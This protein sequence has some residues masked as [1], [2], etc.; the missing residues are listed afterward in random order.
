MPS[1]KAVCILTRA[2]VCPPP[3]H[4]PLISVPGLGTEGAVWVVVTYDCDYLS[5]FN[6][7]FLLLPDYWKAAFHFLKV[8][9][10]WANESAPGWKLVAYYL[11]IA[12]IF[13]VSDD[14]SKT[15]RRH[16]KLCKCIFLA[17][18][19]SRGRHCHI[20]LLYSLVSVLNLYR[21]E[22]FERCFCFLWFKT[23]KQGQS[24]RQRPQRDP[25]LARCPHASPSPERVA[26][27]RVSS[28]PEKQVALAPLPLC[29]DPAPPFQEAEGT[30]YLKQGR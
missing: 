13:G 9:V 18:F 11:S 24:D 22:S 16:L 1:P 25:G 10:L 27:P 21:R 17:V 30:C 23:T 8:A 6:F 29:W 5:A 4:Q 28:S 7:R 19:C 14:I 12:N 20:N 15:V 26:L 3:P 2:S